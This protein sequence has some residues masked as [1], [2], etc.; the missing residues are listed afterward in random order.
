MGAQFPCNYAGARSE[1]PLALPH[2]EGN[3]DDNDIYSNPCFD[4]VE[5]KGSTKMPNSS[6]LGEYVAMYT[7]KTT[8]DVSTSQPE[9]AAA[10]M[11]TGL[12]GRGIKPEKPAI[13]PK[14]TKT[15][16]EGTYFHFLS[17]SV[18]ILIHSPSQETALVS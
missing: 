6:D 15:R 16:S 4:G 11:V 13:R 3:D 7:E 1:L 14:P 12:S 9:S 5:S 10:Q 17:V 2:E 18:G 8:S